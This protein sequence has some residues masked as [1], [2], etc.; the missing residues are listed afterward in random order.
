MF[1]YK[2]RELNYSKI[3]T[4]KECPYL[5][6]QKYIK[7]LREGLIAASSL[8]VSI[9]RTLEA[10]HSSKS[11]NG[12]LKFYNRYFL[13]GGYQSAAEQMEYYLKGKEMLEKYS[14]QDEKRTSEV[15]STEQEFI[16]DYKEWTIRGK[17][18]RIDKIGQDTWEIIDYKTDLEPPADF[19]ANESL[20][21][22]IYSVGAKRYWNMKEG[23]ASIYF[24]SNNTKASADF[25]NFNEEEILE[26]FITTG[27]LILKEEFKPNLEHCSVCLMRN[28]CPHSSVR[29]E[30]VVL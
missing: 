29:E 26:T 19:K 22:G 28:R 21:L 4:Y 3:K 30:D 14:L 7:G 13:S 16:F 9:H 12:I 25:K 5:F 24:I 18:D 20:Q 1:E 27:E 15:F 10:Y 8:G 17:I 6:K 11:L 2:P 23:K